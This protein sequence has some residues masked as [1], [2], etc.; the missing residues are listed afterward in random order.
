M[1]VTY[2]LIY[3]RILFEVGKVLAQLSWVLSTL[4]EREKTKQDTVGF[5]SGCSVLFAW[6]MSYESS[7]GKNVPTNMFLEVSYRVC[8][9]YDT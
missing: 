7:I 2:S 1:K 9:Q 3:T 5:A 4:T 8:T 6:N